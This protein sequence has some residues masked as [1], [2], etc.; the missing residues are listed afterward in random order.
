MPSRALTKP[1]VYIIF[2]YNHGENSPRFG[3]FIK[4]LQAK[5]YV[6]D[7]VYKT[8][9]LSELKFVVDNNGEAK[10]Y[11]PNNQQM[12]H[13]ASFVYFKT[14]E[15]MPERASALAIYLQAK[16]IPF[17]DHH[18][19]YA[20]HSKLPQTFRLWAD[21]LPVIPTIF[22]SSMLDKKFVEETIGKGPY[23]V[24]PAS[25]EKGN[26]IS[27]CKT[28]QEANRAVAGHSSGALVQP[29]IEN[30]GDYRVWVYGYEVKGGIFRVAQNGQF[31]NN[32]S[33]GAASEYISTGEMPEDVRKLAR[34]AAV[35]AGNSVAG[36]DI[37]P[38]SDGIKYV[39]EVN[40]G[41]QI[42]TGHE[43]DKKMKAFG[44]YLEARMESTYKRVKQ[45]ARLQIIGRHV[46]VNIPE[47]KVKGILAKVDTGAYQSAI[48]AS[49]IKEI[50][51]EDG[52]KAL[53]FLM[54]E[55]H[56]K[57]D[58]LSVKCVAHD[59]DIVQVTNTSGKPEARYRIKTAISLNGRMMKTPITLTDRSDMMSPLLLGRRFLRG[60]YMVNV[61]LSRS[62]YEESL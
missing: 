21:G 38:S 29:F 58:G 60:R 62:A 37:L 42:V 11:G 59:Y 56:T 53:E 25:G 9:A 31:V 54:L 24:K 28:A 5:S 4:R 45:P 8:V 16:G 33:K 22:V 26:G 32:T 1:V 23:L 20:G 55:G 52:S 43:R 61:E 36:V 13:D 34:R 41:S 14:W 2:R 3:G 49:D 19:I 30:N 48:H 17:E 18:A 47:F 40:Q 10:I 27:I 39:L 12:F 44:E 50:V 35:A 46:R 57:A 15:K 7:A 6:P 51:L